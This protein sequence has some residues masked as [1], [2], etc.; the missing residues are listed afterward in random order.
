MA[1][2]PAGPC[3][4]LT[5]SVVL[6]IASR[7]KTL[8]NPSLSSADRLFALDEKATRAL[9]ATEA[10]KDV[11]SPPAPPG[12]LARL[13]S[14]VVASSRSRRKMFKAA[15]LSSADRLLAPDWKLT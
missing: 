14:A 8:V 1:A 4:R 13:T 11:A 10:V 9:S 6:A 15:L 7:T 5:S 2:A 3:A 12:P